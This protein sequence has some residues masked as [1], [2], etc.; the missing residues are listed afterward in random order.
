MLT[1]VCRLDLQ[2]GN[3]LSLGFG[4]WYLNEGKIFILHAYDRA[5][6][7]QIRMFEPKDLVQLISSMVRLPK[8]DAF[9]ALAKK[10]PLAVSRQLQSLSGK[11]LLSV[12]ESSK[13][14]GLRSTRLAEGL[15]REA[16]SRREDSPLGQQQQRSHPSFDADLWSN[17]RNIQLLQRHLDHQV[18]ARIQMH[19]SQYVLTT[20][21]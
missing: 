9:Q 5:S 20:F 13:K 6:Q 7:A 14:L 4:F 16:E 12:A 3:I 18:G 2:N 8:T 15:A 19:L 11:Q 10:L 17:G 21:R 1:N